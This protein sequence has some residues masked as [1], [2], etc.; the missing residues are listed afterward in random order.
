M[1]KVF[2]LEP[3]GLKDGGQATLNEEESN[4]LT[5]ISETNKEHDDHAH[6]EQSMHLPLLYHELSRCTLY[7][8]TCFPVNTLNNILHS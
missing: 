7:H 8:L 3:G 5:T 6:F 2:D 1:T 4:K